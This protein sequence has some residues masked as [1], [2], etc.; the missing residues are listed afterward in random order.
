M[1]VGVIDLALLDVWLETLVE[2]AR[3][4]ASSRDSGNQQRNRDDSKHCQRLSRG[5]VLGDFLHVTPVV[6]AHELEDEVSHGRQINNDHDCLADVRFATGDEGREEEEADGHGHRDN[7]EV[8]FEVGEVR[9]DNDEELHSKGK[10]EEKI[11]LEEGDVN[12]CWVLVGACSQM[13][14]W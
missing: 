11:E 9:A 6:H 2:V 10:E 5:Q 7:C 1:L 8:E 12:L 4:D 13:I 3:A 14:L